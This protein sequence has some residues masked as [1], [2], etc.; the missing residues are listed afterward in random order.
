MLKHLIAQIYLQDAPVR[1]CSLSTLIKLSHFES[2]LKGSITRVIKQ[3]RTDEDEEVRYRSV[4]DTPVVSTSAYELDLLEAYL[5]QNLV[6]LQTSDE[7]AALNWDTIRAWGDEVGLDKIIKVPEEDEPRKIEQVEVEEENRFRD[8]FKNHTTFNKYGPMLRV[9]PP[10]LLTE[11]EAEF[12][13][14][15][16]KFFFKEN[17]VLEYTV[18]NHTPSATMEDVKI[19]IKHNSES[20]NFIHL[21][22]AK[23]IKPNSTSDIFL[24]LSSGDDDYFP[25]A[26]FNSL[27]KYRMKESQGGKVTQYEDEYPLEDF[28]LTFTD[29]M[30]PQYL[31]KGTFAQTWENFKAKEI[32]ANYQ[33]NYP[34][35]QAAAK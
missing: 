1:A 17:I 21:I 3:F 10:V 34:N 13:V 30:V 8:I 5:Q 26:T 28:N 24:G 12:E 22:P 14:K 7:P 20:I 31:P 33:L 27:M 32:T 2:E 29:Y 6:N 9:C 18:T 15:L 23:E 35:T 11:K 25:A 16:R 4:V 19:E